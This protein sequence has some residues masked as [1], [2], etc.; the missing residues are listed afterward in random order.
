MIKIR[1]ELY[2]QKFKWDLLGRPAPELTEYQ[3][4]Q[5]LGFPP[6]PIGGAAVQLPVEC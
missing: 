2:K 4:Q 5:A 3:E 6:L 1:I